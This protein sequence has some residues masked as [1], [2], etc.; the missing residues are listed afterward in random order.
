MESERRGLVET[1]QK[2]Q[3]KEE[4][5]NTEKFDL[6]MEVD[7]QSGKLSDAEH[8]YQILMKDYEY[9]KDREAVLM[10]DRYKIKDLC[11]DFSNIQYSIRAYILY[12]TRD[13]S[14]GHRGNKT[15]IQLKPAIGQ[16]IATCTYLYRRRKPWTCRS[17]SYIYVCTSVYCFRNKTA[18]ELR[19]HWPQLWV[20]LILGV[21]CIY[22]TD[23]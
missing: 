22:M 12:Y 5:L 8:K 20:V 15:I 4:T 10:G 6:E 13:T 19:P 9:A 18:P 11:V 17:C 3:Q 7:Q 23:A 2:L 14:W 16:P 21:H 1:V